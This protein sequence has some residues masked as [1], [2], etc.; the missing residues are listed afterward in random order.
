MSVGL[1]TIV[2]ELGRKNE[3]GGFRDLI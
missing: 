3:R 2:T 1:S